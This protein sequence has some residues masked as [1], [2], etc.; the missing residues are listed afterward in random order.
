MRK[1]KLSVVVFAI[2]A[3]ML[4]GCSKVPAGHV[5]IKVYLLG[6]SKG[7]DSEVLGIGRYY[8]GV[9]EELF[10]F[11]IFM[12]NV[13]WTESVTDFS[14]KDEAVRF[15]D[16]NNMTI[17]TDVGFS[18]QIEAKSVPQIFQRHRKG[19]DE[20][21]D[22]Y[23]RNII[24]NAFNIIGSKMEFTEINGPSK[25]E[26][27]KLVTDEI[28]AQLDGEGFTV[29]HLTILDMRPPAEVKDAIIAKMTAQ[30][31]AEKAKAEAEATTTKAKA[32]A[33]SIRMRAESI[34][35]ALVEYEKIQIQ[36][37]MAGKWNGVQSL[38]NGG[39]AWINLDSDTVQMYQQSR[40]QHRK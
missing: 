10:L 1:S 28:N 31:N 20:I 3:A 16:K 6:K 32:E 37:I 8:I 13:R 25:R 21:T 4:I 26:F 35:P 19:I 15:Q 5:G 27:L 23:L 18:Y 14:P 7:V 33:T 29:A 17:T 36:R 39:N 2:L 40:Q 30:Q 24:Q 38:V 12:Q 22:I 9:N 11:P 34:T